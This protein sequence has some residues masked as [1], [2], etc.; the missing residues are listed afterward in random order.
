MHLI[1]IK[2]IP[3]IK[4]ITI[5]NITFIKQLKAIKNK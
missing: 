2:L 1:D 4:I 3:K 5:K